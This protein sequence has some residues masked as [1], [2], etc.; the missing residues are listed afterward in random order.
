MTVLVA[1]TAAA[2]VVVDGEQKQEKEKRRTVWAKTKGLFC[3]NNRPF[4]AV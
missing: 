4:L 2:A 1:I 3:L